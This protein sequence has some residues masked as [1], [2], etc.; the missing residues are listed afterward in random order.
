MKPKQQFHRIRLEFVN[1]RFSFGHIVRKKNFSDRNNQLP[2]EEIDF[3]FECKEYLQK[4]LD[5]K[6]CSKTEVDLI[7]ENCL[8][9]YVK[10]SE[11]IR[12]RL[13][14]DDIFLHNVAVFGSKTALFDCDRDSTIRKVL[15]VN[16]RLGKLVDEELLQ[17]EWKYLYEIDSVKKIEWSKL[18]FDDMWIKIGFFSTDEGKLCF[19]NLRSLLSVVRTLPHSNAEAERVFSLIPDAKTKKR[20]SMSIETLNSICVIKYALKDNN[21]TARTMAVTRE[22]L[23]HMTTKNI[24]EKL[25]LNQKNN[26]TCTVRYYIY[27]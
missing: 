5:Q 4:L 22:H 1:K 11:Q 27:K 10:A 6:I 25:Q 13:P 21:N 24:N 18:C 17:N 23:N 8:Q 2:L 16:R 3:G 19:P 9:F 20:N 15:Q 14:I 26:L 12:A 7:R